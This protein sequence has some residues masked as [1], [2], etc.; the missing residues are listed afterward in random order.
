MGVSH[1]L[2]G[3]VR[4]E[5]DRVRIAAQLI[6]VA[7]E[8]HVWANTY[9]RSLSDIL[10]LQSEVSQAVA[11]EIRVRL[12]PREARRLAAAREVSPAAYEAY[13]KGRHLWNKRTEDGMRKSIAQYEEAIRQNPDYAMAHC[14]IADSY[15]MLACRGM[16]PAKETFLKAKMAARRAIELDPDLGDVHGSMAHVRLHDWDWEGLEGDFQRA[17]ELNPSQAIV[18]YWYGEFLMS[19][20]R[21]EEAIAVTQKAYETD[22]LSAVTGASLGMILYLARRYEQATEVL[23]RAQKVS[24]D[25]FLPHMRLGLVRIQQG[26]CEEAIQSLRRSVDLAGRSTETFAALAVAHSAAGDMKEA[27]VILDDLEKPLSKRY[28][29]PYNIAKIYS[30]SANPDKAFEWLEIAYKEGNPDLIELNSEPLFDGLR[31]DPRFSDLMQRVGWEPG[32]SRL[33]TAKMNRD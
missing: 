30:A 9:E 2:E 17:I 5:A 21:P 25:H 28:V 8:T 32:G 23:Q 31:S 29:L 15:V 27:R 3:S 4:R 26:K 6:E 1:V 33:L 16:A 18:Y 22:P 10:K 13:L 11:R 7:D 12:A 20:G 14:G 19:M 24:P